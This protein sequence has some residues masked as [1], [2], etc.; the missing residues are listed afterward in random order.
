V[1]IKGGKATYI[2]LHS[3]RHFYLSWYIKRKEEGGLGLPLKVVQHR[4]RHSTIQ[5]TADI[6]GHLFPSGRRRC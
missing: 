4:L 5:M 3:L 1:V 6:Y 2:G